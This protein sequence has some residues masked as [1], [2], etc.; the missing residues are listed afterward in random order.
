MFQLSIHAACSY[1]RKVLDELISVEDLG[2]LVSPDAINLHKLV[3]G[4]I[5]EAAVK[6]HEKAPALLLD[7]IKGVT[8]TDFTASLDDGVV[9]ITMKREAVRLASFRMGDSNIVVTDLIPEDSAEGRKQLNKY[10][11]GVADDPRLVIQKVAAGNHMPVFKYYS[12]EGKGLP[13]IH[14]EYVPYPVINETI[15]EICPALEYAVLNEIAAMVMETIAEGD[16]ATICR[17][18]VEEYLKTK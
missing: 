12:T 9:T 2:M 13:E 18:R 5:V 7:G 3:E 15:V 17:A 4:C 16:K 8:G 11:R 10:I 1:V 6:V 14:L